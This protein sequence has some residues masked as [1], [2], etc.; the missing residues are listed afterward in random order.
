MARVPCIQK[1]VLYVPSE[2]IRV[3]PTA[4]VSRHPSRR[5]GRAAIASSGA[6]ALVTQGMEGHHGAG[7]KKVVDAVMNLTTQTE[8][9][10][11]GPH[12]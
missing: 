11:S 2:F 4:C 3:Q 12:G 9:P 8:L 5:T 7:S 10:E 1:F 6:L